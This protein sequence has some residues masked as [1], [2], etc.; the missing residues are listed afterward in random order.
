LLAGLHLG[1][2]HFGLQAACLPRSKIRLLSGRQG[3]ARSV[4]ISVRVFG[5]HH[6]R[7]LA[8]RAPI[9]YGGRPGLREDAVIL[10]G[11]VEL[12]SLALVV[13]IACQTGISPEAGKPLLAAFFP[14]QEG[15]TFAG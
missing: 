4:E 7:P 10:D 13:R 6:F 2:P 9:A 1:Q 14:Y 12:Q 11:E 8:Q 15:V 3:G 5:T